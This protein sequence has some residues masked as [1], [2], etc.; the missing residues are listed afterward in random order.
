MERF[1]ASVRDPFGSVQST[2]LGEHGEASEEPLLARRQQVVA[3]LER[4]SERLLSA[5]DVSTAFQQVEPLRDAL[6][7]LSRAENTCAGG[8]VLDCE[9]QVVE[10]AAEFRDRIAR[11]HVGTRTVELTR[12][13]VREREHFVLCLACHSR[14]FAACHQ[15]RQV[16]A[17]GYEG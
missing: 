7:H 15:Q 12:L 2:A 11:C 17:C 16:G 14:A 9:R 8:G 1:E 3:P 13:S 6:E 5:L 4:R 10:P